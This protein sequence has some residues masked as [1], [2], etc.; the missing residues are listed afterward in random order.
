MNRYSNHE[1]LTKTLR[2][3]TQL[4]QRKHPDQPLSRSTRLIRQPTSEEEAEI[5]ADYLSG[6]TITNIAQEFAFHRETISAVLHRA[7]VE[8]RYHQRTPV[9]LER[10]TQL[11]E[12]GLT[13]TKTAVALGISRTTLIKARREARR[14]T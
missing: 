10:A 8:T 2:K 12:E 13:I 3:L 9:D 7:K 11:I 1:S 4:P 6:T 14:S 5:I